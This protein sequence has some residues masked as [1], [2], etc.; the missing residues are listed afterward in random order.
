MINSLLIFILKFKK[1]I[2]ENLKKLN[3][4][5]VFKDIFVLH[6]YFNSDF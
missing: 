5:H 6:V 1:S 3:S 4:V 2:F